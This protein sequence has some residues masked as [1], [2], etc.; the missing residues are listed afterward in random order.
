MAIFS[1]L[2]ADNSKST[3]WK[4]ARLYLLVCRVA[5]FLV[6]SGHDALEILP[7]RHSHGSQL[8][9]NANIGFELFD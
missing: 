2:L 7:F 5:A 4:Y 3:Q 9:H 8:S 6:I 1:L